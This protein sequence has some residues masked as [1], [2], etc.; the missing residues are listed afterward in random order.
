MQ[1]ADVDVSTNPSCKLNI[2]VN[3]HCALR[4]VVYL[5]QCNACQEQYIG[6]TLT[7]FRLRLNNQTPY[8]K[9]T[10]GTQFQSSL[11]GVVTILLMFR[12]L[13]RKIL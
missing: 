3:A 4:N 5:I 10:P 8:A 11:T 6:Q 12:S 7:A 9:K 2:K 1:A 13:L